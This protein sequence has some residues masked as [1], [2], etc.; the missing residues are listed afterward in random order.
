MIIPRSL[1]THLQDL[2]QY[3]PILSLTGPR[4]AGKTTLL[5]HLFSDYRYVSFEDPEYR[6]RFTDDPRG[7]LA[8]Y[9]Q[10]VIFDEAQ[11]VP[12]LFSYLQ[13]IVDQDRAPGRFVLSGSQN[14]LLIKGI[15][16]SL[17][18]RV[19]LARLF[20]LDLSELRAADLLPPTPWQALH[21]GFYPVHYQIEMPPRFFYPNY[22]ATYLE[23][24]VAE[25]IQAANQTTF[26][27][28]L[29][30]CATLVGQTLN[31][32]MLAQSI[33]L[34]V[35]TVKNWL[36]LLERSYVIFLLPPYFRNIGKRLVKSPKLY[37][38]D[39]GLASYLLELASP[40]AVQTSRH[41]GAL[42]ENLIVADRMKQRQHSGQDTPLFFFRDSNG[43][44]VDLVEVH[45]DQ[46]H[47]T[48]IK[49]SATYHSR[50]LQALH[51]VRELFTE[52]TT[53][54]LVYGGEEEFEVGEVLVK[55]WQNGGSTPSPVLP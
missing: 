37:F 3:F 11:R 30:F 22:L 44:E 51:K 42:F 25:V 50:M 33:G 8:Q 38:Y 10:K 49:S 40:N 17:A 28:F 16:Q 46:V 53:L 7:F 43:L 20:P 36:S 19:G 14:F 32:A 41:N 13:G 6:E 29:Q 5:Q 48:E 55:N 2:S 54:E 52:G 15:T 12:D 9:D 39:T 27:R 45:V 1:A 23:R 18:G 35:P 47:L 26:R 4:Q 24:D 31:Y 21:N 34:S